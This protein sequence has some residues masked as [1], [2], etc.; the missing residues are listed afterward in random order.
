M[1]T[2]SLSHSGNRQLVTLIV[3]FILGDWLGAG[4][5]I[6]FAVAPGD[7]A[8][9]SPHAISDWAWSIVALTALTVLWY[10]RGVRRLGRDGRGVGF[11]EQALVYLGIFFAFA[12]VIPPL[13]VM[14]DDLYFMHQIQHM[15]LH[16]VAP[17][18]LALGVP[19][20]PLIAGLP[21]V[22]RRRVLTPLAR[23]TTVR[24]VWKFL[25]HPLVSSVLFIAAL[26]FWQIPHFIDLLAV[27]DILDEFAHVTMLVTGLFFW[28]MLLDPRALPGAVSYPIRLA[29][30]TVVMFA[31]ILVGAYIAFS[32]R[33]L[34]P[35]Y[36]ARSPGWGVSPNM[37]QTLGGLVTWIDGA[38]TEV[39]GG[40]VIFHRW[41]K[42]DSS[43]PT[44]RHRRI[45]HYGR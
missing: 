3:L 33:A 39:M 45:G 32:T 4:L 38:M 27:S 13:D 34:Y 28:W 19:L 21:R 12:A 22:L 9:I 18:L 40:L 11:A 15:L 10:G 43:R 37:D 31:T 23:N 17:L 30:V 41:L 16:M 1:T 20:A 26:F 14:A 36:A 6:H 8:G 25:L 29:A 44:S 42:S 7:R 24:R 35:V 5:S 2:R